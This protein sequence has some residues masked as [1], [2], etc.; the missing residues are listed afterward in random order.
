MARRRPKIAK[1]E[2]DAA[3]TLRGEDG[4]GNVR[5]ADNRY[6]T[7]EEIAERDAYL[8]TVEKETGEEPQQLMVKR[9]NPDHVEALDS[10]DRTETK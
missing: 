2:E 6:L 5:P 1:P 3:T 9:E 8:A 10:R 7:G 4:N